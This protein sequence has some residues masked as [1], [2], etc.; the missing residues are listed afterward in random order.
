MSAILSKII[1]IAVALFAF[2]VIIMIHELGHFFVAKRCK[3]KVN[4]FAFGMGPKIISKKKG[5][6]LYSWRLLPIGGFCQMEGED[7][8]SDDERAFGNKPVYQRILVVIAGALMNVLLGFVIILAVNACSE[9]ITT[10]TIRAFTKDASSHE[11]GL[12]VD[13]KIIEV[14]GRHVFIAN[15]IS[16]EL[17]N[18]K[19]GIFEMKVIRDGKKITLE[20]VKFDVE[21]KEEGKQNIKIDF[22]VYSNTKTVLNV[23][24]SSV[25]ET[26]ST[27]R[28]VYITLFDLIRGVYG[29]ND[30]SGPIGVVTAINTAS[31]YGWSVVFSLV[32]L[33][34]INVGLFNL[35]PLP[36]LDGGRLVFLIIEGI[37]R[38]PIKAKYE[39][40][41]HFVG[42]A[43]LMLL[44]LF[45]SINDII[46]I[47][48]GG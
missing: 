24:T 1:T 9:K 38:K 46:R 32:S 31:N 43:L 41:I 39:S 17:L 30:M 23:F 2:G 25:R 19:D 40:M 8:S 21:Q 27:A 48:T 28:L 45:V 10:T 3:I 26:I 15:D 47:V 22:A 33:I 35:L 13:D 42:L 29:I 7:Q 11:T 14:N 37:R 36:A 34:A 4:E 20:S 12:Q 44:M 6:T 16:Y 18:D 5:E